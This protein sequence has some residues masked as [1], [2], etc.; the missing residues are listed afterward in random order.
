MAKTM[1]TR[2]PWVVGS[3]EDVS[4]GDRRGQSTSIYMPHARLRS[5][6]TFASRWREMKANAG[7]MAAAPDLLAA[8]QAVVEL[9]GFE[10]DEPYGVAVLAAI[11]KATKGE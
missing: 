5:K 9:P 11:A 8:L 1:H 4:I 7:I 2:G 10:P 6:V 3:I